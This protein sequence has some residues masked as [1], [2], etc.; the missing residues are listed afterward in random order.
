MPG[1]HCELRRSKRVSAIARYR[2]S[3]N[4]G[5]GSQE[6]R[7]RRPRSADEQREVPLA[8]ICKGTRLGG[9]SR[10]ATRSTPSRAAS[11]DVGP[12]ADRSAFGRTAVQPAGLL[13]RAE[14][15][16]GRAQGCDVRGD[17]T[18][19]LAKGRWCGRSPRVRGLLL[20]QRAGVTSPRTRSSESQA[21]Q[22][23]G[24]GKTAVRQ[25]IRKRRRAPGTRASVLAERQS[26]PKQ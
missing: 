9:G 22:I 23:A 7:A 17:G 10:C 6:D 1:R 26:C 2:P 5:I 18:R 16:A 14:A 4:N 11:R 19:S 13:A 8:H 3:V 24:A 20:G 21:P 25:R 15:G 12:S